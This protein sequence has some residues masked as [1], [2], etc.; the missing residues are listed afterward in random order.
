MQNGKKLSFVVG[1]TGH[2]NIVKEDMSAIKAQIIASL[3]EI[4][5]FCKG[6]AKDGGDI[7]VVML[8]ALAQGADML[9]AEA[10]FELGIAV[11][12]VL[13]CGLDKY[14]LSFDGEQEKE[15][16]KSCIEK[17]ESVSV[18]PDKE[19]CRE[20]L[21]NECNMNDE[22]YEYRQL[23]IYVAEHSHALI[24]LWDGKS[25]KTKYGCGT[26]EVID[27][28]L[29]GKILN[30][31]HGLKAA[32]K[33]ESAVVWI[34][35]RRQGDGEEADIRTRWL[36]GSRVQAVLYDSPPKLLGEIVKRAASGSF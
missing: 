27:F 7:P 30:N 20:R 19:N 12:A 23:G 29:D 13:P 28:A 36:T 33:P 9:C 26:V 3:K 6:A 17:C 8:N 16:L 4:Q 22:S 31:E 34:K 35:C 1:V 15:K 21:K 10:A 32:H 2:R 18:A 24:A 11:R 25:P 5:S 14:A